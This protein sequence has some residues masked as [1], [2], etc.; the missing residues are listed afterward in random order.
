MI[1]IE[2]ITNPIRINDRKKLIKCLIT[3]KY[4]M[5]QFFMSSMKYLKEEVRI[6]LKAPCFLFASGA[7]YAI[8]APIGQ[9]MS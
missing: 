2:W 1:V 9:S 7:K 5:Q 4:N 6:D 3:S 8:I